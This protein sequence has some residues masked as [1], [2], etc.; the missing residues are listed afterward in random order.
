MVC[1][2]T[3]GIN[4]PGALVLFTALL[5]S[6]MVVYPFQLGELGNFCCHIALRNLRPAGSTLRQ[7]PHPVPNSP[8][9]FLF[10]YVACPN[11]TYETLSWIGF[12]V[13]TQTLPGW[14]P[15]PNKFKPKP[16]RAFWSTGGITPTSCGQAGSLYRRM[17]CWLHFETGSHTFVFIVGCFNLCKPLGHWDSIHW[18]AGPCTLRL[19]WAFYRSWFLA[20]NWCFY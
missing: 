11:Y 16:L 2:E 7:M 3:H 8:L 1:D 15:L 10:K 17:S 20:S 19:V 13:M 4:T 18:W 9:T 5:L 6:L 12:T 14:L